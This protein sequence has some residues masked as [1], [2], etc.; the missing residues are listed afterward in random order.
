[1][2]PHRARRRPRTAAVRETHALRV[3]D[4]ATEWRDCRMDAF[5]ANGGR[6]HD[7]AIER[8]TMRDVSL[9]GTTWQHAEFVEE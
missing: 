4:N 2:P 6:W 5:S 7:V 8:C 3:L 1:M 9:R